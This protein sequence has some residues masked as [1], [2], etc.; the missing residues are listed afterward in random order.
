MRLYF[1]IFTSRYIESLTNLAN[2]G[3]MIQINK[4]FPK[5]LW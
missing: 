1:F 3:M 5:M 4:Y 2:D